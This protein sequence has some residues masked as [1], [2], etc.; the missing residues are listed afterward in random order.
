M[1]R[2]AAARAG[3]PSSWMA[4]KSCGVLSSRCRI[5]CLIAVAKLVRRFLFLRCRRLRIMHHALPLFQ[6]FDKDIHA[7]ASSQPPSIHPPHSACR[8]A[9]HRPLRPWRAGR[10]GAQRA[11]GQRGPGTRAA[12]AVGRTGVGAQHRLYH[13]GAGDGQAPAGRRF[14]GR[15]CD[16][17]GAGRSPSRR[18]RGGAL[19]RQGQGPAAAIPWPPGC[20]GSQA[21]RLELRSLPA[22]RERRLAVRPRHHRHAGPGRGHDGV[23]H[24]PE[25]GSLCAGPRHHPGADC[26]RGSRQ[27]RQRHAVAVARTPAAGRRLAGDQPGRRRSGPEKRPRAIPGGADQRKALHDLRPGSHR[28]GRPQ[29]APDQGQP[30]LPPGAWIGKSG[31]L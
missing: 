15:G 29:L 25:A 11:A 17:A 23:A 31:G 28:Q 9:C 18:Q 14:C 4:G 21:R 26:Q 6:F 27:R 5:G 30:D 16:G 2:R 10:R 13:R 12:A 1:A 24:P 22:D 7:T 3:V 20:G 8:G 19:A